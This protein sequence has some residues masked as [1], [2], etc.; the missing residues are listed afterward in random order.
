MTTAE[1]RTLETLHGKPLEV[2]VRDSIEKAVKVLKQKMSKEGILQEIKRRRYHEK[3]SVK[4]K[5]KMREARKR[6]RREMKRRPGR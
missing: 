6:R 2:E 4:K 3:P 5:R 1:T